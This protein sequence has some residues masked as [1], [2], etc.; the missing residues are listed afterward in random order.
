MKKIGK[1]GWIAIGGIAVVL[2]AWFFIYFVFIVYGLQFT[3]Y[4]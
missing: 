3:V 4:R 2:M 1:K